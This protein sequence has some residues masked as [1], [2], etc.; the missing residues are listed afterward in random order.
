M[1]R[2]KVIRTTD[3][4]FI[5]QIFEFP[6]IPEPGLEVPVGDF[7]FDIV[8]VKKIKEGWYRFSNFNYDV[9]AKLI[10]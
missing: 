9:I 6:S 4:K 8:F 3:G 7:N 10:P 1:I 2:L 5:G